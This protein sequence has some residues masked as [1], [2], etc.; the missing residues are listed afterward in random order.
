MGNI[1]QLVNQ[2][3]D[4]MVEGGHFLGMVNSGLKQNKRWCKNATM[5]PIPVREGESFNINEAES[6][7]PRQDPSTPTNIETHDVENV[8]YNGITMRHQKQGKFPIYMNKWDDGTEALIDDLALQF[9]DTMKEKTDWI[10]DTAMLTRDLQCRRTQTQGYLGG[11]TY[12]TTVSGS[13]V[14]VIAVKDTNGFAKVT[15]NGIEFGVDGTNFLPVTITNANTGPVVRN[16]IG[17]T[18]GTRNDEDDT[19]PGTITLSASVSEIALAI[20]C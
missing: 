1:H 2:N 3:L 16:V 13:A 14:T 12:S 9:A 7:K 11:N 10:A 20:R 18:P 19:V 17:V 8:I 6:A 4:H 15:K 5:R